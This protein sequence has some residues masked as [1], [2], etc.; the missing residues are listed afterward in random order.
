MT[1]SKTS[2]WQSLAAD[3]S[4]TSPENKN[5][6]DPNVDSVNPTAASAENDHSI[7]SANRNDPAKDEPEDESIKTK[8]QETPAVAEAPSRKK[9]KRGSWAF[10]RSGNKNT[11]ADPKQTTTTDSPISEDPLA[12]LNQAATTDDMACAIDQLFA[13][14]G[15]DT[16]DDD[17]VFDTDEIATSLDFDEESKVARESELDEDRRQRRPRGR[18]RQD[19][20]RR[21]NENTDRNRSSSRR[22]DR[23]GQGERSRDEQGSGNRDQSRSRTSNGRGRDEESRD[24]DRRQGRRRKETTSRSPIDHGD[25]PTWDTAVSFVVDNNMATRKGNSGGKQR[26]RSRSKNKSRN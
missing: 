3:L 21:R 8:R 7:R 19:S 26:K 10:W 16:R 11:G 12:L 15:S 17:L 18:G 9:K 6:R 25:V 5:S 2:H 14:N 22:S 23:G 24:S 20:R 4:G 1:D 13:N